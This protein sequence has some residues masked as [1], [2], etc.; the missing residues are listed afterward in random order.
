MSILD[1][2]A[3]PLEG[4]RVVD[5]A[6][7]KAVYCSKL[8]ADLGAEVIR[9]ESPQH[10]N[11][12]PEGPFLDNIPDRDHSLSFWYN[13]SGRLSIVLDLTAAD[14]HQHFLQLVRS[15]DLLIESYSPGY[16]ESLSLSY[17]A[18]KEIN[19]ALSVVSVSGF[20]REGP[21]SRYKSCDI[22]ASASGG[23]MY[24]CGRQGRPPLKPFG[25]QSYYLVSL[26]GAAGAMLALR[27]REQSGNGQ[28]VDLSL[29]E[30][31]ASALEHVLVQFLQEGNVPQR[32]GS[33]Q[34]NCA[35][36]LFPCRDG[37]VLLTFNREW[38]PLVELLDLQSMAADLK[39]PAWKDVNFRR[40]HI[41]DIEEVITMWSCC[42]DSGELFRLGQAMRFPW[43]VLNGIEEVMKDEQLKS[44]GFFVPAQHPLTAKEFQVPRPVINFTGA[45]A[46]T[47][48]KVPG[49]GE[50]NNLLDTKIKGKVNN[51]NLQAGDSPT[52]RLPL[53]GIRVLDFTWILAGPYATRMLADFGAEVIKV[54]SKLTAT[55]AESNETGYFAAW[56][57]NKLGITL[58]MSLPA[59][60][61]LALELVSKSDVVMENFTP[62]VMDNW[63]LGYGKLRQVKPDLVMVSLSG[64]GHTGPWRYYAA[65]GQTVQAL[66][67]LT[68]LT[69]Y[70][71][72][73]PDG[74]G[75]AYADHISG[76]YAALAVLAALRRR[77]SSGEGAYVDIS[78]YEAA[79]SLLGPA[80]MDLSLNGHV[81]LP[82]GNRS[83][84][85]SAAPQGCYRCKGEDRWCVISVSTEEEWQSLCSV[86]HEPELAG[87]DR[88]LSL[89]ARLANYEE[90][91]ELIGK[92]TSNYPPEKVMRIL[93]EA[94]VPA[95]MVNDARDLTR[96]PGLEERGFFVEMDHPKL[97][98]ISADANP[99]KLNLTP[100][101]YRKAAPLLGEDNRHVFIDILGMDV[102][103]FEACVKEG[104]IA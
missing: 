94:G 22:V 48:K 49:A 24:V 73:T 86:M 81:A 43:A 97:G 85:Q 18:L 45:P 104:I 40:N 50:Q 79:C 16:L 84:G 75:L 36:D 1:K 93:Q 7:D 53:E 90:L 88:F 19:P 62:R 33:L 31:V 32:Q 46:Y 30:A 77:D 21:Y 17:D 82:V 60:R 92:W 9:V 74:I 27:C 25:N 39:H 15:S 69:A 66:S 4:I 34:W 78:E 95:A 83:E 8:L 67:G 29:Q 54:Q 91:D 61:E 11:Y 71:A 6:D 56:N 55:G 102:E 35:S 98:R 103:R 12:C 72:G 101:Q 80:F 5:L 41:D 68:S 76:L 10:S 87:Q 70:D 42:Q 28:H 2:N 63:G 23:Q 59:A 58:D 100:A 13:N 64:F 51:R 47:W 65:L 89:Q 37:Y 99:I 20:G 52:G 96:D 3:M 14:D 44:R 38:E 57:R 26:L